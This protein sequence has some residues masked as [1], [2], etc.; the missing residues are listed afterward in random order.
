M[1][2]GKLYIVCFG[3]IRETESTERIARKK[4]RENAREEPVVVRVENERGESRDASSSNIH[5]PR[6]CTSPP[7]SFSDLFLLPPM[8]F[9]VPSH[10]KK[11]SSTPTSLEAIPSTSTSLPPSTSS[12][13]VN[14]LLEPL[15]K[16]KWSSLT[17]EKVKTHKERLRRDV[18]ETKVSPYSSRWQREIGALTPPLPPLPPSLRAGFSSSSLMSTPRSHLSSTEVSM[19]API[20]LTLRRRSLDWRRTWRAIP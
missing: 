2:S 17:S 3:F 9:E 18:Q 1:L 5:L 12:A 10:L 7:S 11:S 6:R 19:L 15:V 16:E 13:H 8:A 4:K 14:S 20:P